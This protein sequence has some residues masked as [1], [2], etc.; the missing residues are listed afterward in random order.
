MS[1]FLSQDQ[2]DQLLQQQEKGAID[3]IAQLDESE[4]SETAGSSGSENYNALRVAFDLFNEH[5][6]A[7]T[8]SVLSREV[9]FTI[10]ECGTA[11]Q[12]P[13]ETAIDQPALQLALAVSGSIAGVLS[14]VM[15]QK[16]VAEIS[17]L[18]IMGS[19]KAEYSEEHKD[20][21]AELFNQI[22]GAF[23]T[24]LSD[25][26]SSPVSS[27]T[28]QVTD[29]DPKAPPYPIDESDMIIQQITINDFD[30]IAALFLMPKKTSEQFINQFQETQ[31][32][33]ADPM[34]SIGLSS[35][36]MDDLAQISAPM[37]TLDTNPINEPLTSRGH[38]SVSHK[39][40]VDMLLD[41][42]MN[43]C[44]ELGKTDLSIKRILELAPG[45]IVELDR[46]AGEP[47]DLIVNNKVVAK[48][49]VVVVDENF[50][51]RIVSLIS[52][53]ER[54]KSLR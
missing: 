17:D 18:M 28:I 5:G 44:I 31:T 50:G 11:S 20:A 25:H 4:T 29:F 7:V 54:I 19:G 16:H 42:E 14:V 45:S 13:I 39:E 32:L 22:M 52:P 3:T 15:A 40:N 24:A 37:D 41:I 10:T 21:I 27:G 30:T 38:V 35:N 1:E 46:M 12:T 26:C 51:I 8:S 43:V 33:D 23:C 2:I 34:A 48:G 6:S 47:V 49:E 9:K 36:E 53:E